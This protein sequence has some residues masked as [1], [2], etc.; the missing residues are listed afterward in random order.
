ML[1]IAERVDNGDG[2]FS[3]VMGDNEATFTVTLALTEYSDFGSVFFSI[4]DPAGN[5]LNDVLLSVTTDSAATGTIALSGLTNACTRLPCTAAETNIA[6]LSLSNDAAVFTITD[7]GTFIDNGERATLNIPDQDNAGHTAN[8]DLGSITVAN[9]GAAAITYTVTATYTS[10]PVNDIIAHAANNG[11]IAALI[12]AAFSGRALSANLSDNGSTIAL[13]GTNAASPASA[14]PVGS[15]TSSSLL[16]AGFAVTKP[17]GT[18]YT[19]ADP[20]DEGTDA[21][22]TYELTALLSIAERELN[23]DVISNN[24]AT[25]NVTLSLTE[26][27]SFGTAFFFISDPAGNPLNDVL[28]SVTADSATTATIA[29]S[30]L[31]N[32]CAVP[33]CTTA[34][35]NI[36]ALSLSHDAAV[37]TITDFGTFTDNGERATLMIPDQDGATNMPALNL[38]SIIVANSG[39]AAITYTVTATY[40]GT[41]VNDIIAHVGGIAALLPPTAVTVVYSSSGESANALSSWESHG[42][43]ITNI[44]N[45]YG[46][47]EIGTVTL[48]TP[49]S[50]PA[51]FYLNPVTYTF[52][53]P[54]GTDAATISVDAAFTIAEGDDSQTPPT[55]TAGNNNVYDLHIDI[56]AT[57]PVVLT[58]ADLNITVTDTL[59]TAH[60]IPSA[61]LRIIQYDD[62]PSVLITA[63]AG[64]RNFN[65]TVTALGLR[66]GTIV[67]TSAADSSITLHTDDITT[68]TEPAGT[69]TA[70]LDLGSFSATENSAATTYTLSL[71]LVPAYGIEL[72]TAG[73]PIAF[74]DMET[75]ILPAAVHTIARCHKPASAV[76]TIAADGTIRYVSS[77]TANINYYHDGSSTAKLT[78][79]ISLSAAD[80]SN[81]NF[82]GVIA[83]QECSLNDNNFA[84]GSS[85]DGTPE[86]PW[87]LDNDIRLDLMSRLINDDSTYSTYSDDHYVLTANIDMSDTNAPWAEDSTHP[88]ANTNGFIPIGKTT[89][90][91]GNALSYQTNHFRGQLDCAANANV[92]AISKLFISNTD[93]SAAGFYNGSFIGLFAILTNNVVI[94][95][96]T[97]T[98]ANISGYSYTGGFAGTMYATA[99]DTGSSNITFSGNAMINGTITASRDNAGGI[100]GAMYSYRSSITFS[101]NRVNGGSITATYY[102]GGIAGRVY[103]SILSHNTVSDT[104]ILASDDYAGGIAGAL[105]SYSSSSSSTLNGNAVNG[106]SIAATYYAG[107]IAGTM[108][109]YNNSSNTL[110]NNTVNNG[111]ITATYYAGGILGFVN[112]FNNGNNTLSSNR[113]NGTSIVVSNDYA[114]GIISFVLLGGGRSTLSNNTVSN[115]SITGDNDVGGIAGGMHIFSGANILNSNTV[116]GG[117]SIMGN[118]D[119]GGIAGHV[120]NVEYGSSTLGDNTVSNSS[121]AGNNDVG[122]IVGYVT[123]TGNGNSTLISNSTVSGASRITGNNDVGGIAGYVTNPYNG[124]STLSSNTVSDGS[125][126][127]A[128]NNYAGGI[129]GYANDSTL[130]ANTLSGIS[131]TAKNN[132]GGIAGI[133][134]DS[135]LSQNTVNNN[136]NITTK[137]SA[138]GIA[139]IAYD[140]TLSGNTTSGGSITG[141]NHVGGIAG[142]AINS[143]LSNNTVSGGNITATYYVGGILGE[144]IG[145]SIILIGNTVSNSSI[146]VTYQYVGG[147]VGYVNN[148]SSGTILSSNAIN[149][150]SITAESY[151]G[152]IAGIA[153]NSTFSHNTLSGGSIKA[154][155]N[156]VGGIAGY[157]AGSSISSVFVATT[158]RGRSNIGGLVGVNLSGVIQN[159]VFFGSIKAA[160]TN[161]VEGILMSNTVGGILMSNNSSSELSN[162]YAAATVTGSP[163]YGLAPTGMT[164][165]SGYYDS[166]LTTGAADAS[167]GTRA[168]STSALQTPTAPPT[169]GSGDVYDGWDA[170]NWDFGAAQQYPMLKGLPLTAAE[171]CQAADA[172]LGDN[173]TLNC[174]V[175]MGSS[176][177]YVD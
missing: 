25:F 107:G 42:L 151:I 154:T 41:P 169:V 32:A 106:G 119:V 128:T 10:T 64:I 126:I 174:D 176:A 43:T 28:L 108:Q 143:T 12:E 8:V 33:P 162:S 153:S 7:F 129:A 69:E 139:G 115:T 170:S 134:Y 97:L 135:T 52:T 72:N 45:L 79:A 2:T 114:G 144:A 166:T 117:S 40:T 80:G 109:S 111:S 120:I 74:A 60:N 172:A 150:S 112:N 34:E 94:T 103:K 49:S 22:P 18:A 16:P 51:G 48:P 95:N 92:Y 68:F 141:N 26:Y 84:G 62:A 93:N 90:A 14:P 140:S 142:I 59:G 82:D 53:D 11:G 157:L 24:E 9:S 160:T 77:V 81:P 55:V 87:Q 29:L 127:T 136:N 158:V 171:Q 56:G 67:L 122:G 36:A 113:V 54:D 88:Q 38:G 19:F 17:D 164:I 57:P 99:S 58:A 78:N 104:R 145:N 86:N 133:A 167:T 132:A 161:T 15:V 118:N 155:H 1:N 85:D 96:C 76:F 73:G 70:M 146:A 6:A 159:S 121:I 35:T 91:P 110:S 125:S 30:G 5:P 130:S 105:Q 149:E 83:V 89:D 152:G 102:A 46:N 148:S 65:E 123:T 61:Q 3:D 39:A 124:S 138:G 44:A 137:N 75:T 98:D 31:T 100:T 71:L 165:S 21:V 116:S 27:S 147:I 177:G 101:S 23:G 4:S 63:A 156:Y 47:T 20:D 168:Q 175:N 66:A 13:T 131:I 163:I 173:V 37:F 50:L